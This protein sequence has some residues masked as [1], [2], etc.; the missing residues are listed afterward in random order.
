MSFKDLNLHPMLLE[1][2]ESL[3]FIEP[4]PIQKQ[5]IPIAL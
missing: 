4:T 2:C 3:G 1:R 5:A